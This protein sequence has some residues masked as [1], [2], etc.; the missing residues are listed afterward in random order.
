MNE[1]IREYE[2]TNPGYRGTLVEGHASGDPEYYSRSHF[3]SATTDPVRASQSRDRSLSEIARDSP[4]LA[5]SVVPR[6]QIVTPHAEL[7]RE[8]GERL[9]I[10]DAFENHTV[11][12]VPN[13][14]QGNTIR[15]S[16]ITPRMAGNLGQEYDGPEGDQLEHTDPLATLERRSSNQR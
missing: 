10:G 2:G 9:A 14:F 11:E 12:N 15:L 4:H 7:S 6:N 8:E 13:P 16:R 5:T 3:V 1:R